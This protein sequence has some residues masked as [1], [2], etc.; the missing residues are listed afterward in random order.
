MRCDDRVHWIV[1]G[2]SDSS[3][4]LGDS[5][6]STECFLKYLDNYT[7]ITPAMDDI[8]IK[9]MAGLLFHLALATTNE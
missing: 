8:M 4:A 6:E 7:K 3:S 1:K 9:I 5:L 2:L